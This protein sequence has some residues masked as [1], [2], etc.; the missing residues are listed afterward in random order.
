[1]HRRIST[2]LN[3]LRQDLAAKLGG[4]FI[5]SACRLANAASRL[6]RRDGGTAAASFIAARTPACPGAAGKSRPLAGRDH[7]L[8][9]G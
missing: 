1:M 4:D 3:T 9:A 6:K 2:T 8:G 7:W 5:H